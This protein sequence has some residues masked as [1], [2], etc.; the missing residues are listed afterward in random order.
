M[1]TRPFDQPT[2]VNV[3][4]V[5]F[6]GLRCRST[7]INISTEFDS[8][9]DQLFKLIDPTKIRGPL[10][11]LYLSQYM[12]P[13]D[14][15]DF[16]IGFELDGTYDGTEQFNIQ[17]KKHV[18][19]SHIGPYKDLSEAFQKVMDYLGTNNL[20]YSGQ[21]FEMYMNSPQQTSED[22]LRTDIYMSV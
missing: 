18:V 6:T 11:S 12:G 1:N 2:E 10:Y 22:Q 3:K 14:E 4:G 17:P 16:A 13:T 20:Q 5:S 19:Y 8:K 9:I 15:F 21:C 7:M